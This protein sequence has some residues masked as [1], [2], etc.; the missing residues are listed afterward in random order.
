MGPFLGRGVASH[1]GHTASALKEINY[2]GWGFRFRFNKMEHHRSISNIQTCEQFR[3][4]GHLTAAWAC[5]S[6]LRSAAQ[7]TLG[8]SL[9]LDVL[10]SLC[11][12]SRSTK[13]TFNQTNEGTLKRVSTDRITWQAESYYYKCPA[14]ATYLGLGFRV[15]GLGFGV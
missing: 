5:I 10:T 1:M 11:S 8:R 3:S 9:L 2:Q 4:I 13:V 15:W 12:L 7:R 14:F 6:Q